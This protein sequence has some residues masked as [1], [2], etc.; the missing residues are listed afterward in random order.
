MSS[1]VAYSNEEFS[2]FVEALSY[3]TDHR[4]NH[5]LSRISAPTH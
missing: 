2:S 4:D 5:D 3:Y 1:T